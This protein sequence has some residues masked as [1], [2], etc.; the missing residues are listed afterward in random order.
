VQLEELVAGSRDRD[1]DLAFDRRRLRII[2]RCG[3]RGARPPAGVEADGRP[4]RGRPMAPDAGRLRQGLEYIGCGPERCAGSFGFGRAADPLAPFV[5][6]L[7][8][9]HLTGADGR[10][11]ERAAIEA[12]PG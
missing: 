2:R 1:R 3:R 10:P 8:P 11:H 12:R 4:A 9:G 5:R 7:D 6:H